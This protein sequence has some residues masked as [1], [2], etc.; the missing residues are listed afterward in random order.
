MPTLLTKANVMDLRTLLDS[1]QE[2]FEAL[3]GPDDLRAEGVTDAREKADAKSEDYWTREENQNKLEGLEQ[4]EAEI[5]KYETAYE[6]M[7]A[8]LGTL[9]ELL[10]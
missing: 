1:A 3:P 4:I 9:K 5:E 7:N 8:A 6:D 2:H 10:A